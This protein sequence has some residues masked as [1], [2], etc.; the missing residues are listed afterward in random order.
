[1]NFN[2]ANDPLLPVVRDL[3][4]QHQNPSV[5]FLQ[6]MLTLPYQRASCLMQYLEGDLVSAPDAAGWRHILA[7]EYGAQCSTK[8]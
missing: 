3:I 2:P 7:A 6:R 8:K 4:L 1:M 5:A